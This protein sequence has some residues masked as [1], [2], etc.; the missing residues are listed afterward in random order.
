MN[1]D[2]AIVHIKTKLE[3]NAFNRFTSGIIV[4][5]NVFQNNRKMR[6]FR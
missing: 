4:V 5:H 2:L 3:L 6:Q 1:E